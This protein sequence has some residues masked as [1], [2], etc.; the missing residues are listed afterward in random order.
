MFFDCSC[1]WPAKI[2]NPLSYINLQPKEWYGLRDCISTSRYYSRK[3]VHSSYVN[4]ITMDSFIGKYTDRFHPELNT[5]LFPNVLD[6]SRSSS[7]C[8]NMVFIMN[9]IFKNS[10]QL[11]QAGFKPEISPRITEICVKH[12]RNW[13]RAQLCLCSCPGFLVSS[14]SMQPNTRVRPI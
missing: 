10:A 8:V 11:I 6:S 9:T 13:T 7:T 5:H 4:L 14:G 1:R 12:L 2:E 3:H